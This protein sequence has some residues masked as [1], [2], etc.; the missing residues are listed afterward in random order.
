[1][2]E[3]STYAITYSRGTNANNEQRYVRRGIP[4]SRLSKTILDFQRRGD[5]IY[6]VEVEG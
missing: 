4:S 6:A 2:Y 5:G 1:M 3:N